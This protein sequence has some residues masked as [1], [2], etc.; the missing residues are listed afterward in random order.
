MPKRKRQRMKES[1]LNATKHADRIA[2]LAAALGLEL[3]IS[4]VEVKGVYRET[5]HWTFRLSG[6]IVLN[7]WPGT[8][9]WTNPLTKERGNTESPH[10]ALARAAMAVGLSLHDVVD[11][12]SHFDS[13]REE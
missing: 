12:I 3:R 6:K 1:V 9:L 11:R 8:G 10:Q 7:Y 4:R 13:I 5:A 2:E